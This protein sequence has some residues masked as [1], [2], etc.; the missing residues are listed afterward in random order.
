M[1]AIL[2]EVSIELP[3]VVASYVHSRESNA[4]DALVEAMVA[5]IRP[6]RRNAFSTADAFNH[7]PGNVK[8]TTQAI[9]GG[10]PARPVK[11]LLLRYANPLD[12]PSN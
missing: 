4:E 3:V 1:Q 6:L 2:F 7:L 12:I 10:W 5:L 11:A 9:A 8:A